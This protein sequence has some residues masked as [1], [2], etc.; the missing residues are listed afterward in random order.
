MN[1]KIQAPNVK[2]F[3]IRNATEE[4]VKNLRKLIPNITV[5]EISDEEYYRIDKSKLHLKLEVDE[6]VVVTG[7]QNQKPDGDIGDS[8]D[9]L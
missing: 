7:F 2:E 9:S 6:P 5:T 3:Y 8:D 4:Y 1:I